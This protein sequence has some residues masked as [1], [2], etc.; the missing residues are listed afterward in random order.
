MHVCCTFVTN[1]EGLQPDLDDHWLLSV[2]WHFVGFAVICNV[3]I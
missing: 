3:L 2:L 1:T